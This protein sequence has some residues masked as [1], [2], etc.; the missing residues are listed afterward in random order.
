MAIDL[1]KKSNRTLLGKRYTTDAYTDGQDAFTSVFDI[2]ST[3]VYTQTNL[4][5]TASLP[6]SGSSQNGYYY[7]VAGTTSATATGNDLMRFWYRHPLTKSDLA[8]PLGQQVWMFI[9][10]SPSISAGA[11]LIDA[12][13][14]TNFLS[15]KYGSPAIS[16]NTTEATTPGYVVKA[17][18]STNGSTFTDI[19]SSYYNFDYKTGLLQFTSSAITSTVIT[20]AVNGRVY[21]S[22]YQ[23]VGKTLSNYTASVATTASYALTAS[24]A[25]SASYIGALGSSNFTQSFT[26]QSTWTINH[27]LG[28]RFALIQ[29]YDTG[30]DEMIPQNIDLTDANTATVTFPFAMSG[31]AV[32]TLGGALQNIT[33]NAL[34]YG[35]FSD[36]TTQSGSANTAYAMKLNTIDVN[37]HGVS[38][39]SGS[40]ITVDQ[41]ATY[42]L[43]FSSQF[44]RVASS[45]AATVSIW[46][47]VTGSDIANSCTDITLN[48]NANQSAT[49]AAWN[50][51]LPM[52]ASQYCE[53]MWSTSDANIQ[54][55]AAGA[56]T[57]PTRPAVP[58][59]IATLTQCS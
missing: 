50:F 34:H 12:N 44:D 46:L 5:P 35:A 29:T 27:N 43:Q 25:A 47:R 59:V 11:Q 45:G 6:F 42:N 16:T 20:D 31:Y 38:L 53:L 22:A 58:S 28:N 4:I 15:P 17:L 54:I 26:N 21:L 18:Y 40:R 37:G 13:Q 30:Y 7:T 39:V 3:E 24:Y 2:N 14:Q 57:S 52:S 8:S 55:V 49:V 19:D 10:G 48:G 9:S 33:S 41:S 36:T 23:Y 51:V 56:R 1:T 32:A